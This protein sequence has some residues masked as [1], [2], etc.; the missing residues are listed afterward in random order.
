VVRGRP[1]PAHRP[2]RTLLRA[3]SASA[4]A[5]IIIKTA[6]VPFAVFVTGEQVDLSALGEPGD[7]SAFV[8]RLAQALTLA[9]FGEEMVFRGYLIRR[10]TH[11][12]GDTGIGRAAAVIASSSLFGLAHRYQGWAGV[13]ATGIIG[14]MLATLF[15]WDRKNL[16]IVISCHA[17]VDAVA[18]TA[19]YL[20][21]RSL[22]FQ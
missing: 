4:G 20:G 12:A 1:A 6:I 22:L 9:A 11:L 3:V 15:L 2:W 17:I 8:V 19:L 21:H 18:L 5:L 16:W 10:I 7:T 13:I 14:V